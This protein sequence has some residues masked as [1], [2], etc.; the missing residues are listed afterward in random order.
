MAL[1]VGAEFDEPELIA[2]SRGGD[3]AAFNLLVEHY[4]RPLYNLCLRMMASS[5]A[6]EDATQE[7]FIAAHRGIDRFRGGAAAPG[8][9][10]GFRAW[11]FRIGVNACYDEMRRRRAR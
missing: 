8:R 11:L 10:T 7:A 5:E 2:R 3:L 9:P 6:A 4:Q 1:G